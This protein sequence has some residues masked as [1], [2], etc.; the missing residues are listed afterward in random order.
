VRRRMLRTHAEGH[1]L[2]DERTVRLALNLDFEPEENYGGD[3]YPPMVKPAKQDWD[4]V[5][6]RWKEYGFKK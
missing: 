5:E 3:R 4:L 1:V 6:Q 2:G